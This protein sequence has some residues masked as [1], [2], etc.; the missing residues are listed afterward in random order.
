MIDD[1][2]NELKREIDE[3]AN[4]LKKE[5]AKVRT[6]RAST[7]LLDGIMVEYYGARTPLNQLAT[8]NAP[9][10]RLLVVTPFDRSAIGEIERAI[11]G[12]DLGL[13]PLNDG[14][15][16]RIPIPELTE[17]R[18]RDLVKHVKKI[19][20]D[21]RV[22]MRNHRRDAN[23]ML[24]DL[25]KEKQISEDDYR[26]AHDKVQALTDEGIERIDR[27]LKAKEEEIMVV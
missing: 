10:P 14:K 1:V 23:E 13:N 3:T 9:E 12:S 5:F 17:E 24:K 18:R 16:I 21:F 20:E 27:T 4:K 11:K 15:L 2:L 19:A 22:S 26:H 8:V 25:L 6:G 7:A